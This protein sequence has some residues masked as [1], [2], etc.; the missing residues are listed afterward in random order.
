MGTNYYLT[1]DVCEHCGRGSERLHIGKSS[2]GWCFSLHVIPDEGINDL[3]DWEARWSQPNVRIVDEYGDVIPP[4][5]MLA[6]ITNRQWKGTKTIDTPD[7]L[8]SNHAERGPRGLARYRVDGHHCIGQG[9]GTY[10]LITGE[11]S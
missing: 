10:D 4:E 2:A 9:V 3:S 8:A 11:F 5:T 6:T 1:L 7:W